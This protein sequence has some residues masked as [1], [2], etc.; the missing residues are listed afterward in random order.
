MVAFATLFLGLVVGVQTVGVTVGDQVA[1]VEILLD[2]E[3]C[4]TVREEPFRLRCDFGDVLSPH[5]LVAVAAGGE[6]QELGRAEQW[7]NLP[8]QPAETTIALAP[9]PSGRSTVARLSWASLAGIPSAVRATLDGRPIEVED[10]AEIALPAHDPNQL[11][12]LQV[13]VDFGTLSSTA[14]AVF[15][16]A[17]G[18]DVTTRITAVPIVHGKVRLPRA[19]ELAGWFVKRGEPLEVAAVDRGAIDLVVVRD[20]GAQP[21]L[22]RIWRG[23]SGRFAGTAAARPADAGREAQRRIEFLWP[24]STRRGIGPRSV[25]LFSHSQKYA[26]RKGSLPALVVGVQSPLLSGEQRLAD[27]VAVAGVTAASG[28]NRRAVVLVVG[29]E[30]ADESDLSARQARGYLERLAVPLE[31]W[32]VDVEDRPPAAWPEARNVSNY[33]RLQGANRRLL[34]ELER[35]SV[36]WLAG[37]HLPHE[38]EL[39]E[40]ARGIRI[41][42]RTEASR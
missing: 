10:A 19:A 23:A 35:Q 22:L 18:D 3:S 13:E 1:A 27:A 41:A 42:G 12:L 17:Y 36:V 29:R 30:A 25:D 32:T 4:G 26:G 37:H 31:V 20:L 39:S 38:I 9:D 7:I 33:S 21:D 2:G 16:G 40:R 8:R 34:K 6:G 15:G 11:H 5:Y 14:E 24:V 28:N